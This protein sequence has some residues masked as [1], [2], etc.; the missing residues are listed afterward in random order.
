MHERII[1]KKRIFRETVYEVVDWNELHQ[2][3]IQWWTFVNTVMKFKWISWLVEQPPNF[4]ERIC[5]IEF[6]VTVRAN[7]S[8]R[9][10]I[11]NLKQR[12][13]ERLEFQLNTLKREHFVD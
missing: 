2:D 9:M 5:T 1:K 12:I 6:V 10:N 3:R 4:Q 7:S 8:F 13:S 11:R